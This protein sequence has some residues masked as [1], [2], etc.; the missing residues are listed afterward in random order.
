MIQRI[1][2]VVAFLMLLDLYI[3][4][5]YKGFFNSKLL[6][7]IFKY[8]YWVSIAI[9]YACFTLV[10][11]K[12]DDRP[13]N[14]VLWV[15]LW[16][17]Y[18]FAFLILKLCLS[19]ILIFEDVVRVVY[20][21]YQIL[22]TFFQQTE[23]K[24]VFEQRRKFIK[25]VGLG[26]ASIPFASM[27]YGITKGKYNYKVKRIAL[28]F[29]N[30][31]KAFDGLKVV[32]ISDIHSG[33]FDDIEEVKRGVSLIK[34]EQ[35]DLFL[36]TGDLVNNQAKEILPFMDLFKSIKA[37]LGKFSV[38]G[39][40]DYGTHQKWNSEKDKQQ[41]LEEL[42][43]L[44]KEMEFNLLN[45]K[46]Q[47]IKQ[48]E[49]EIDVVGVE[50]WGKP[51]FPQKGDL[52]LA[53]K[54]TNSKNFKILL[55]HDPTHWDEKVIPNKQHID[56]TLSGHTHGMQFGIEIPG[57]KWSPSKYIY[58]QW[59]GLYKNK[60]KYLYVNRGFG[61]LGFPGRVGIWPEITVITLNTKA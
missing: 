2:I 14:S 13:T 45:N 56:L 31:P 34:Q 37:P 7:H 8:F 27:I 44:Q 16:F 20:Y 36:F 5:N 6:Q 55:S 58:K 30:L 24:V 57:F 19:V 11:I 39:N 9:S 47:T 18:T 52:N 41:N 4:L 12:I 3:L 23:K 28:S 43:T 48:Q 42:K 60:E 26:I 46:T 51:P 49:Q 50:N 32:H 22:I 35:P 1:L 10:I 38:L 25:Q 17:G 61:F 15:N 54:N 59:A 53:L 29:K 40:H 21:L 33:S